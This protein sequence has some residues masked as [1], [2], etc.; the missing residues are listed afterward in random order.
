SFAG[1]YRTQQNWI[2]GS[3]FSPLDAVHIP[4]P[5]ALVQPLMDDLLSFAQRD[6]VSALAQAAI[7]HGQFEAIHP[8]TDGN[9][10]VGRALISALLRRRGVAR[11][12]TVPIAAAMLA[13]VDTY[14][15]HLRD[16]RSGDAQGLVT[17]VARSALTAA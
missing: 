15:K 8:F 5:T 1:R 13:D 11:A 16:Y 6:D 12:A 3:D 9:G 17:Y 10:R 2:G 4:P 7:A 14:F